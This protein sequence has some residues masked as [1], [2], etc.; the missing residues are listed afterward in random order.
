MGYGVDWSYKDVHSNSGA[1]ADASAGET[2]IGS[3]SVYD[4]VLHLW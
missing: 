3:C 2:E 1:S 4:H